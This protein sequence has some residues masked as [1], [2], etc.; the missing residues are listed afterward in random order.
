MD[1]GAA[2]RFCA[3]GL[4]EY[5][6]I[7]SGQFEERGT[8][9]RFQPHPANQG[10]ENYIL[11]ATSKYF[12]GCPS[13]SFQVADDVQILSSLEGYAGQPLG[14]TTFFRQT[15]G[16]RVAVLGH[17]PEARLLRGPRIRQWRRLIFDQMMDFS[18]SIE[19]DYPVVQWVRVDSNG[20]PTFL[21][22]WNAGFDEAKEIRF[23]GAKFKLRLSS[24]TTNHQTSTNGDSITLPGWGF[25]VLSL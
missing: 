3:K 18:F 9:E 8:V 12:V 21:I 6:G 19:T 14:A 7:N 11:R 4:G 10:D 1:A 15:E 23:G 16:Q 22:L 25:A 2:L 24:L 17:L 13:A 5:L 20:K